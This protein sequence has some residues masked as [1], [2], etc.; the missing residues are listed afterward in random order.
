MAV[1]I[2]SMNRLLYIQNLL[3][4]L[5]HTQQNAQETQGAFVQGGVWNFRVQNR[6]PLFLEPSR[7]MPKTA[8]R[9]LVQGKEGRVVD[10]PSFPLCKLEIFLRTRETN[11]HHA[12]LSSRISP[13]KIITYSAIH[14]NFGGRT[15]SQPP[16]LGP[17]MPSNPDTP[18]L[19]GSAFLHARSSVLRDPSIYASNTNN[20]E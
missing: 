4:G 10:F 8:S 13:Q 3:E 9:L 12:L 11:P 18:Q 15:C 7:W 14:Y 17:G 20:G 6:N 5:R 19:Q 16:F 1:F 2:L